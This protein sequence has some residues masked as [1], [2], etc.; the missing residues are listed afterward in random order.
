MSENPPTYSAIPPIIEGVPD[1][2]IM[3]LL[4][5]IDKRLDKLESNLEFMKSSNND[6]NYQIQRIKQEMPPQLYSRISTLED[7]YKKNSRY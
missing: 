5:T 3:F 2:P 1:S 4:K 7:F 6:L